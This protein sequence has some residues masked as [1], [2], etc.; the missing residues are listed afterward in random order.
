MVGLFIH[1]WLGASCIRES[2]LMDRILGD[3]S[4]RRRGRSAVANLAEDPRA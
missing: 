1:T 3:L 4:Q 2:L